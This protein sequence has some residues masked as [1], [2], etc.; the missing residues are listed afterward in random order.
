MSA[1]DQVPLAEVCT[2]VGGGTPRR[3]NA[4]YFD[5]TV[6][7]AT[8]TDVTALD[9]LFIERT[10]EAI[11][12]VGLN[13]SSARLVPAGTVLMTSRATIGY[14]AIATRPMAT[15]Q[16]FAKETLIYPSISPMRR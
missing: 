1:F 11:T 5:G 3:S 8:P 13:E 6:P 2:I 9:S 7:W 12:E 4:A 16:G 14:T 10:K 15:N